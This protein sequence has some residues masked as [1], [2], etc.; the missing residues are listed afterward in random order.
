MFTQKRRRPVKSDSELYLF[1]SLCHEIPIFFYQIKTNNH[2]IRT[3][4]RKLPLMEKKIS[5]EIDPSRH[6]IT[7]R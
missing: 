2:Y 3:T 7:D 5:I 1:I 4:T 6:D